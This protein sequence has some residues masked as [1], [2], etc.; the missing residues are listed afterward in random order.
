V[1]KIENNEALRYPVFYGFLLL[2]SCRPK[3]PPQQPILEG[4][5]P[6]Q[7]A[8]FFLKLSMVEDRKKYLKLKAIF[9]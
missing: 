2:P 4:F 7:H 6:K 5:K 1:V 3:N 9:L 8:S